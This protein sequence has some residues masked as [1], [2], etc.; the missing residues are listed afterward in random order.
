MRSAMN[1]KLLIV[2]IVLFLPACASLP[3]KDASSASDLDALLSGARK[4]L[5]PRPLPN[6]KYY[7]VEDAATE[8]ALDAC[9]NALEDGKWQ[10]EQDKARGLDGI[11][12][13]VQRLKLA[14]NPCN[15]VERTL[16]FARCASP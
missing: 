14:R 6:G 9:A 15:W 5:A 10:S 2:L 11:E 7:C 1:L 12:R 13:G 4:N 8:S 3:A 16:R